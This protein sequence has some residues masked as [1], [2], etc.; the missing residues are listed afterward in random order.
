[1][2][3]RR[4]EK[5]QTCL[6][7][8]LWVPAEKFIIDI[9]GQVPEARDWESSKLLTSLVSFWMKFITDR[10]K[11]NWTRRVSKSVAKERKR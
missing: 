7:L 2:E 6:F 8:E 1:M 10:K 5:D 9:A 4:E 11:G 3:Y